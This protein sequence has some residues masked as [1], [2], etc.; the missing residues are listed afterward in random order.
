MQ[1]AVDRRTGSGAVCGPDEALTPEQAL[2]LYCG[3]A[4]DP[5]GAPRRIA[6]GAAA[7]LCLLDRPWQAVRGNLS[8]ARVRITWRDGRVIWDAAAAAH[9]T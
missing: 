6:A 2:A 7:D 9:G 4:L 5:G 1:A 3:D 8:D